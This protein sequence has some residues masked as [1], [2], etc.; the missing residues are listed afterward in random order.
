N[1]LNYTFEFILYFDETRISRNPNDGRIDVSSIEVSTGDASPDKMVLLS[2]PIEDLSPGIARGI[3]RTSHTYAGVGNYVVSFS[4][5]YRIA[6]IL[7]IAN[8]GAGSANEELHIDAYVRINPS[9]G[10]NTSPILT[11]PPLDLANRGKIYIHN[12]GAYDPD[13]DSLVFELVIPKKGLNTNVLNYKSPADPIFG[14]VSTS[15]GAATIEINRKTGEITWNTPGLNGFYNIAIRISEYRRGI[16]LGYIV[17]DMQIDVKDHI[18]SPPVVRAKDEYCFEALQTD[19]INFV[20]SDL[21]NPGDRFNITKYGSAYGN[22]TSTP[23]F[24]PQIL[25]SPTPTN[26][27]SAIISWTPSCDLVREQPYQILIKA[28]ESNLAP[29][30]KLSG[31]KTISIGVKGPRPK[32]KSVQKTPENTVKLTWEPYKTICSRAE[33]LKIYRSECNDTLLYDPCGA[34][35]EVSGNFQLIASLNA[36]DTVFIDNNNGLPFKTGVAYHYTM[37][38]Y[39]QASRRG[40]SF[41]ADRTSM[42][43]KDNKI[44]IKSVDVKS[45]NSIKLSWINPDTIG[46]NF[47]YEILRSTDNT[48]YVSIFQKDNLPALTDSV[49]FDNTVDLEANNYY[50][51]IAYYV[52][53]NSTQKYTSAAASNLILTYKPLAS[54]AQI[55]WSGAHPYNIYKTLIFDIKANK[56][57]DSVYNQNSYIV[58]NLKSC[59]TTEYKITTYQRYCVSTGT[60][61]DTATSYKI[62]VTPLVDKT[63][64]FDLNIRKSSCDLVPCETALPLPVH[65]TLTWPDLRKAIC[66]QIVGYNIYF[67]SILD[68]DFVKVGTVLAGANPDTSFIM[69]QNV[70]R[71]GCYKV[72]LITKNS[73]NQDIESSESNTVCIN[74]DCYC[75]SLPNVITPNGDNVNDVLIPLKYPRFIKSINFIIYNRWGV[76]VYETADPTIKWDAKNV[77]PGVYYYA[78]EVFKYSLD[79]HDKDEIKGYVTVLK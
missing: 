68:Q 40:V 78:A 59:D 21:L 11:F 17:R 34:N 37:I 23:I 3:Y 62:R 52:N 77:E 76:K 18:N 46:V 64:A 61:Y 47:G 19:T 22:P 30:F 73:S 54:A 50:Y 24:I 35:K 12:P 49:F 33:S 25:P 7:N 26:P 4:E 44:L 27:Y 67:K 38:A 10:V 48:N 36:S 66:A 69:E 55:T 14:G 45:R 41:A 2:Q 39:F 56:Y 57:I 16:L 65:D 5:Q 20:V 63:V 15:G 60:N 58:N 71:V 74:N 1:P 6:N 79:G 75:Y 9:F 51:K 53:G 29:E 32:W 72:K 13:G 31:I 42:V 28:E 70:T 8:G 43:F